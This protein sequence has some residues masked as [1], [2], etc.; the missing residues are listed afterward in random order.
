MRKSRGPNALAI[1][2]VV[3]TALIL[4]GFASPAAGQV[5]VKVSDSV[6][7]RLGFHFQGTLDWQQD[8]VSEGYSQNMYLRR[9]RAIRARKQLNPIAATNTSHGV[10]ESR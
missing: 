2:A 5:L 6:F 4:P 9:V 3:L 1:L 8:P 10:T 7:F